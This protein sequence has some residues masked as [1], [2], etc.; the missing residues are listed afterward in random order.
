MK[1][2]HSI[3][4]YRMARVSTRTPVVDLPLILDRDVAKN[5]NDYW[6][7]DESRLSYANWCSGTRATT[8]H[9]RCNLVPVS[10]RDRG[11][12]GISNDLALEDSQ[13]LQRPLLVNHVR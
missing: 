11:D 4:F 5:D 12:R 9:S 8:D 7:Q 6:W 3:D 10:A 13:W 1:S 2:T